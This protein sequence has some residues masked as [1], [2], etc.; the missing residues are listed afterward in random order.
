MYLPISQYEFLP[1]ITMAIAYDIIVC[2]N[3]NTKLFLWFIIR[4]VLV[5]CDG[6]REI[7]REGQEGHFKGDVNI[8]YLEMVTG[9]MPLS[10]LILP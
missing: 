1:Y 7:D 6:G 9:G 8:F 5:A 4:E 10:K 3:Q 2:K